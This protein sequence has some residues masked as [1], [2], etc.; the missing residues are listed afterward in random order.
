MLVFSLNLLGLI[1]YHNALLVRSCT[2]PENQILTFLTVKQHQFY[3]KFLM[4]KP[5]FLT[6][7]QNSISILY[8]LIV[9]KSSVH[10]SISFRGFGCTNGSIFPYIGFCFV[11]HSS[12]I[13]DGFDVEELLDLDEVVLCA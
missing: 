9:H 4:F 1:F 10:G 5:A 3:W 13:L 2:G 7:S 8:L 6:L 11:N 12:V